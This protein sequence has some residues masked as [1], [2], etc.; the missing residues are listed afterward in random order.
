MS[1]PEEDELISQAQTRSS[2]QMQICRQKRH[3][4][5]GQFFEFSHSTKLL[6]VVNLQ[7]QVFIP[8]KTKIHASRFLYREGKLVKVKAVILR[9]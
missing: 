8:Q 9:T 5:G 3:H 2:F 7:G 4:G 1:S 6:Y